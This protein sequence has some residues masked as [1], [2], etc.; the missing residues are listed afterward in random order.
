MSRIGIRG[1]TVVLIAAG[2]LI[3]GAGGA[4]IG[5]KLITGAD[6]K[7]G[8]LTTKD[9]KKGTINSSD[10]QNG[11]L[12]SDDVKND[13]LKSEDIKQG[14]LTSGDVKDGTLKGADIKDGGIH[15]AD[16]SASAKASVFSG[17]NWGV[18][19]RNVQGNG[20][21]Y[22]RAGPTVATA[23]GPEGPPLGVGS[24]GI[25][26]ATGD[27]KAAFGN[28]V[29][30]AGQPFSGITAV[31]YSMFATGE[32]LDGGIL[33]TPSPS[34]ELD[35]DPGPL[36][37]FHTV[38]YQPSI[39]VADVNRWTALD[40]VADADPHWGISGV[41]GTTCDLNGALCTFDQVQDFLST[42]APDAEILTV[43]ITKGSGQPAFSG[44]V[45]ALQIN[46]EVFDFE[47]LGVVT[48][49]P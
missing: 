24:L 42:E 30:F 27:D 28:Q 43:Q 38:F 17:P 25:R 14:T 21:T 49:A 16:L 6:V 19:D 15:A 40:A 20:D 1:P 8:S 44:A 23:A 39:V 5:A 7:D 2:C 31:G 4:A 29:D 22:L 36:V 45:D 48:T 47:P 35:F 9:I 26:T 13:S 37:E 34:F 46:D 3:L 41:P 12:K 32:D 10:V 18:V 33:N 11:S